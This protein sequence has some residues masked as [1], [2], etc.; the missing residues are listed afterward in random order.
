VTD[1]RARLLAAFQ[2]EHQEQLEAIR[3]LLTRIEEGSAAPADLEEVFRQ[4]HSFRAAARA[5]DFRTVEE[6]GRRLEAFFSGLRRGAPPPGREA[7]AAVRAALDAV[8][9]WAA[10]LAEGRDVPEP[11]GAVTALERALASGGG[12][13]TRPAE[14]GDLDAR[15]LAAFQ[16]EHKEHLEAIRAFLAQAEAG[17]APPAG[18]VDEA[19]RRAH[20]LK[21]AARLAGLGGAETLAHCLETLFARVRQGEMALGPPARRAITQ[22]LD[23][24]EDWAAARLANRAPPDTAAALDVIDR[25]LGGKAGGGV[26]RRPGVVEAA[27][28]AAAPTAAAPET[29]RVSAEYLDRLLGSAEQLLAESQRQDLVGH[30]LTGLGRRLAAL[31]KEWD[32]LRGSATAQFR[33]LAATPGLARVAHYLTLAEQE[34]QAL[35][36]Q[37]RAVGVRQR[38]SAWALRQLGGQLRHDVRRVR[39][40]PAEGLFQG[41]RKMVRDLA[42]DEGK[43]VDF[44][45]SGLDLEADRA[46]LQALKDPV[47]HMLCNAVTHGIEPAEKRCDKDKSPAGLVGLSL[48]AV[49]NHLRVMVEDDGRGVNAR[50]VAAVAV[51]RGLLS[52]AEA[53]AAT[54]DELARLVFRPAFSTARAVTGAAGRGMGLSV[55][56]EA[57]ARL[58]GEATVAPR[59]GGGTVFTL[60]VPLSVSTHRLLL[61]SCRGQTYALPVHAVE[62]LLRV[63]VSDVTSVEG[64]PLLLLQGQP[65]ALRTLAALLDLGE[66]AVSAADD[67]L[68]VAVLRWGPRRV[69]VAVDGFLAEREA[70]IKDL[71]APADRVRKLAGGLLL[72]DG[73]IALVLNPAELLL[74]LK[75]AGRAPPLRTAPPPSEKK[76]PTV[77]VVDDSLTTRTLE[78][79]ILEAHGYRVR[80]AVDGVEALDRL[81]AEPADLVLTD[82]QMPRM[83]GFRLLEEIKKDHRLAHLPVIVVTSQGR[84][85]DQER[86]LALGADAYVVKRKFD[87]EELLS[88]IRQ[89]L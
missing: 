55:V 29:V 22:G 61:V 12:A 47:M 1:L 38:Q 14:A 23:A 30:D 7:L 65:V 87:H 27:A 48:E 42:R 46:V 13:K 80:L 4:A 8:E 37:T 50:D 2:V 9:G 73:S 79:S 77:L 40:V 54:P 43:E 72:E 68:A 31:E 26:E 44:R 45:V 89:I 57:A 3:S 56:Y 19:F 78:K 85:E 82:V 39:T 88:T 64:R 35:A 74:T 33:A 36:R 83:D 81:R 5:C 66:V 32:A 59:D 21:G 41:F 71:D 75:P 60:S 53:E 67:L 34:I 20:S 28:P 6:L 76:A 62:R 11:A 84:Q 70:I 58:Q 15:V 86:G 10:G 18:A 69:A 17:G 51:R 52:E 63:R 16:V 24:I 25:V 49:G